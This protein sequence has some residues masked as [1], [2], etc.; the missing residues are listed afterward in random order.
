MI[1]SD[2]PPACLLHPAGPGEDGQRA[3]G[4]AAYGGAIAEEGVDLEGDDIEAE[5]TVSA[6]A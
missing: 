1:L 3:T 4:K 2:F 6:T 5:M